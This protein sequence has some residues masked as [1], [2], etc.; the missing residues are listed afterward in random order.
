MFYVKFDKHFSSLLPATEAVEKLS[1]SSGGDSDDMSYS[2]SGANSSLRTRVD[3]DTAR[4]YQ[5][6][7]V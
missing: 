5:R 1:M 3:D 4:I 7:Y 2:V 6:R